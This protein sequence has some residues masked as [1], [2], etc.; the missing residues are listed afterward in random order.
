MPHLLFIYG[1]LK[2]GE[3]N[4]RMMDGAKLMGE[5]L[6]M[7]EYDL[8]A[9]GLPYLIGGGRYSVRGE[10]WMVMTDQHLHDLD[11]FEGHPGFYRRDL[12]W[13]VDQPADVQ[14]QS[15]FFR[16]MVEGIRRV[17]IDFDDNT[18]TW[19]GM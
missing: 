1:T 7:D 5:A 12:I 2:S 10:L 16:G 9:D 8:F 4:N 14:V 15:Y 6:T 17:P 18:L 19:R 13:L 3:V 11:L